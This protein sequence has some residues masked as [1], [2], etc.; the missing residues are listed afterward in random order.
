M[1]YFVLLLILIGLTVILSANVYAMPPFHSQEIYDFSNVIAV[2]KVISVNSTF[3]PTHNLYEIKVEK[4]LKNQQDSD[5][6]FASGQ[7]TANI[8]LGNQVFD[9]N[10]RG[11][12][13]L[14]NNTMGYDPY[15]GIFLVYPTSQLIEPE[16]DKCNIFDKEIPREHWVFGGAGQMPVVRQ[17]NNTDIENFAIG[18]EVLVSYD[19][20]NHSLDAKNATYGIMIKKIDESDYLYTET[21]NSYLLEPCVPYKTLTWTFTPTKSGQYAAEIYDLGGSQMGVGFTAKSLPLCTSDRTAC[22]NQEEYTCDPAG[23]ECEN[24]IDIFSKVIISPLKQFKSGIPNYKITCKE[25]LKLLIRTNDGPAACVKPDT[26]TELQTRWHKMDS[27]SNSSEINTMCMTLEKSKDTATFFKIP[28]YLPEG[29]SFKC[30]FSGTPYESYLI[31]DNKEVQDGWISH[32]PELVSNG[33]IFIH[34]T[35]ERNF[36]GAEKFET[37]GTAEQRIQETYDSVINGNPSLK[38]QLI[39]I[40]GMLAY[41]VDSCSDCGMQTANFT[42]GVIIQKTATEAKIK[43]IDKNGVNY[44]IKAGIPLNELIKVAESLQ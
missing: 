37:F 25:G 27:K 33:A 8:R 31:F 1:K 35:D 3:S 2:G 26:A 29:Y 28:S 43:F 24:P 19:I 40:N 11:L 36:V 6:L 23:W 32:Y 39:R 44:F 18:K 16:W 20:F 41:A 4:F 34:Q 15:S 10:D 5:M 13:Y 9:V 42:D 12:F 7:K 17:G 14:T 21:N 22:S 30:S 38:P